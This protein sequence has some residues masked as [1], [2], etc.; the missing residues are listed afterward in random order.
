MLVQV[1]GDNAMKKT[2]VYSGWY[3]FL[4]EEKVS[5]MKREIRTASN[6]QNWRKHCKNLSNCAWKSSADCQEHSRANEHRQRNSQ[7]NLNWRSWHELGVC[8]NGPKGDH[9]RTKAKKSHNL[10]R[11]FGEARWHFGPCHHRWW[12]MGLPIRPWNEA[13]KYTMEDCQLPTT[14]NFIGPNQES[15]QCWW[16]FLILEGLFIMNLYQ[17]DKQSTKFTIWKYWRGSV[18]S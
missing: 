9:R 11:P 15:K 17:L 1:H 12:N 2:A 6:K 14:K 16:I 10:S 3:V 8:K 5:L 13:A 18:K 7:E 4:R